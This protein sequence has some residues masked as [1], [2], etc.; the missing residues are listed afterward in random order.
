MMQRTAILFLLLTFL[1]ACRTD[2]ASDDYF[3][4]QKGIEWKYVVTQPHTSHNLPKEFSVR[5]I[6]NVELQDP[7]F[8][9]PITIRRTSDGTDYYILSAEDGIFRVGQKRIHEKDI[10]FDSQVRKVLPVPEE[11]TT[12]QS[13]YNESRTYVLK[14]AALDTVPE[15]KNIR[16]EMEFE[17][18]ANNDVVDVP[19][20]RFENCI[21]VTGTASFDLYADPKLGYQT[22]RVEQNEWYAPGVGMVKLERI[23]PDKVGMFEGGIVT[24][25]LTEFTR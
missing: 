14:G 20:G 15:A 23:E 5:N 25:E 2:I 3:P 10:T 7:F 24:Y 8:G 16:F 11:F 21:K 22:V 18:T 19:A 4:L 17:I 12:N 9:M 6:G 13:W 1:T